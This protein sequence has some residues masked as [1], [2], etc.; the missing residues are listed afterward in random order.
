MSLRLVSKQ[1]GRRLIGVVNGRPVYGISGSTTPDG[2]GNGDGG[3]G[4]DS[5]GTG[6]GGD[7][8]DGGD[9]GT[10]DGTDGD[11]PDD[12]KGKEEPVSREEYERLKARMQA[13][14]KNNADLQKKVKEFEDKERTDLEK[15]TNDLQSVTAERDTLAATNKGLQFDLAFALNTKHSWQDPSIVMDLVRKAEGITME[16]DGTITGMTEALDKIAKDK[17]FLLKTTDGNDGGDDNGKGQQ[18]PSGTSTGSGK[19]PDGKGLD[20]NALR[21]KYPALNL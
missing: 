5:G 17:P 8:S 13:S 20:E 2:N 15:A 10:G 21:K 11:K 7:G 3:T 19:K 6:D 12:K 9:G 14:D 4:G 1:Q 18:N 16:E